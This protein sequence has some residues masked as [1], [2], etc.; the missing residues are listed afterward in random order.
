MEQNL[1]IAC[2]PKN[3]DDMVGVDKIVDQIRKQMASGRVPKA[4]LFRFL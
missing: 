1:S 3:L 4:W 2:R